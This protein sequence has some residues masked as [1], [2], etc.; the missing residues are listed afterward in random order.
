MR[1][2]NVQHRIKLFG[3]PTNMTCWSA[4]LTMLFGDRFS[5]GPGRASTAGDGG[6]NANL[7]NIQAIATSYDLDFHA[8]QSW[9]VQGLISILEKGPAVMMGYIPNGHAVVLGGITSD[10]TPGGTTLT[11]YDPW[12]PKVGSKY[13]VN[14]LLL[15]T[16][17]PK[18]TT[19]ILQ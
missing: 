17:F 16:K 9:T 15:M 10:G 11:V 4:A 14:Y 12:P 19:Y 7:T 18:A 6:L 13:S 3:Q 8:P 2:V 5:A 1:L